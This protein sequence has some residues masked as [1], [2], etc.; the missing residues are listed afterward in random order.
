VKKDIGQLKNL[1]FF[2]EFDESVAEKIIHSADIKEYRVKEVIIEEHQELSE[3]FILIEG[4]VILGI[5]TPKKGRINLNTIHPGQIFSWS[6][7][8][9]P[10]IST[11]FAVAMEPVSALAIKSAKLM[12]MIDDD[13][14]FGYKFMSIISHTLSQRLFNTRLQLVNV[15][16]L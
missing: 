16:S 10:H 5:H 4:K 13:P 2:S 8:F 7:M 1:K 14:T 15:I 3:L 6:A 9:P 11:A 12:Q